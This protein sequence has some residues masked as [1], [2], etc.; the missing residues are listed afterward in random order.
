MASFLFS[1]KLAA[2][3]KL[4]THV[5]SLGTSIGRQNGHQNGVYHMPLILADY[6]HS[7]YKVPSTNSNNNCIANK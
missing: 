4:Q 7:L 2:L 6:H 5:D 1:N 3:E